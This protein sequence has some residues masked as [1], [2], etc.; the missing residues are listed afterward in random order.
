MPTLFG[1]SRPNLRG[2]LILRRLL[3]AAQ[4]PTQLGVEHLRIDKAQPCIERATAFDQRDV[5]CPQHSPEGQ[6]NAV[7]S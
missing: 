1:R 3:D 2:R 4:Q 5:R 6:S 7:D